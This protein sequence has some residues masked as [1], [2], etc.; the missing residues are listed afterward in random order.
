M[1]KISRRKFLIKATISASAA[2]LSGCGPRVVIP[3]TATPPGGPLGTD[4]ITDLG[5]MVLVDAGNFRMGCEEGERDERPV[6][7]VELTKPFYISKYSVTFDQFDEFCIDTD[8]EPPDDRGWGRGDRPVIGLNWYDAAAFCNWAS[9]Q[10]GLDRCYYGEREDL[11]WD[12]LSEGYRLPTEAEWEYAARGG[13]FSRG[14]IYAGSNDPSDV[15]WFDDNSGGMTHPV[16]QKD[17][18]E[19]GLYDM[20]GNVWEFCWDWYAWNYYI[21]ITPLDDPLGA[22]PIQH[23]NR[24]RRG[25][26]FS[27]DQYDIRCTRR[28]Y[29]VPLRPGDNGLRLARTHWL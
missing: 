27:S 3:I 15:A 17:P 14:Y 22:N 1:S 13:Q 25:G 29:D 24:S 9:D 8:R 16:G 20:S 28:G 10:A 21:F 26:C 5:E 6:H 11:A 2:V 18:N 7:E 4:S 23:P 12:V 19:L